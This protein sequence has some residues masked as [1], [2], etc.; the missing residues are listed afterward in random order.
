MLLISTHLSH[1]QSSCLFVKKKK[2]ER[3]SEREFFNCFFHVMRK[4]FVF[5]PRVL[6]L[7]SVSQDFFEYSE[8]GNELKAFARRIKFPL[9][10]QEFL[11]TI[12]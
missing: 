4:K 6:R 9:T 5:L 12:I 7:A 2:I 3:E 10:L 8:V 1:F 11:L